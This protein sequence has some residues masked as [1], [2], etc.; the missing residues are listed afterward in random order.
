MN[1]EALRREL[2]RDEGRRARPYRCT[3]GKLTIGVGWNLD[4]NGLPETIIDA[5]FDISIG[6][7]E[8]DA[9]DLVPNFDSLSPN[10]QRV[11]VNMAFMGRPAFS[12]FRDLFD[13][14]A[15]EDFERAAVEM[16]DS[17]WARQV[18][19]RATRLAKRMRAG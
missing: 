11:L 4:D 5:L 6:I 9:R 7:A 2:T 10:R 1:Y 18:G 3:S 16:L 15:A 12:G 19:A 14:L 17:K 8:R 13:A